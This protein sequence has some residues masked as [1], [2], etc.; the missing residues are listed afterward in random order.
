LIVAHKGDVTPENLKPA[1]LCVRVC[2]Y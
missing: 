2:M 1:K